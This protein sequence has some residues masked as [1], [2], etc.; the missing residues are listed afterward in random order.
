MPGCTPTLQMLITWSSMTLTSD[1]V[2]T[3]G[4]TGYESLKILRC[5]LAICAFGELVM[6]MEQ[7]PAETQRDK[8]AFDWK[9]GM[10]LGGTMRSIESVVGTEQCVIKSFAIKRV[11]K[12]KTWNYEAVGNTHGT[13]MGPG[14]NRPGVGRVPM[15]IDAR[16]ER[17]VEHPSGTCGN[18]QQVRI[19]QIARQVL[20]IT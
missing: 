18:N 10:H 1:Q 5:D 16:I 6:S 2:G 4:E 3:Y 8:S 12:R 13:R 20:D 15:R 9:A 19:M 14:P 7:H 11:V 17:E